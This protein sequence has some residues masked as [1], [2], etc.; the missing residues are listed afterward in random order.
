MILDRKT[1]FLV[2]PGRPQEIA[3]RIGRLFD[4]G[5]L[6]QTL[7][8]NARSHTERRFSMERMLDESKEILTELKRGRENNRARKQ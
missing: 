1:G 6:C 4:D 7:G 2:D 8:D 5:A 3:Q